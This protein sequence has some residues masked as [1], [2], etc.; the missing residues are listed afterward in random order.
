M[1]ITNIKNEMDKEICGICYDICNSNNIKRLFCAHVFCM[2][3]INKSLKIKNECPICRTVNDEDKIL[4]QVKK[5]SLIEYES[6]N[7]RINCFDCE[8]LKFGKYKNKS[9]NWVYENDI[10]YCLW[11]KTIFNKDINKNSQF[12]KFVEYIN[13]KNNN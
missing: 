5:L 11:C 6:S 2:E 9:F 4:E 12:S 8:I 10:K 1:N 3:C 13:L 7:N